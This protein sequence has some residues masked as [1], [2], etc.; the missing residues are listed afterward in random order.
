MLESEAD[1]RR[2]GITPQETALAVK[3]QPVRD[4]LRRRREATG[5]KA[6]LLARLTRLEKI[7]GLAF[8][9]SAPLRILLER[10]P[11]A[12]FDVQPE[13]LACTAR[14][15]RSI[16][17]SV[18]EQLAS[19]K[20]SYD[21]IAAEAARRRREAGHADA[22]RALSS[23]V[24]EQPGDAAVARDVA[25]S[26]LELG[27]P[28]H[29]YWLFER[30][31]ERR[32][33]E[34]QTWLALAESAA[35]LDSPLAV[36]YHEVALGAQ[37]SGRIGAMHEICQ[38]KYVRLLRR[39]AAAGT[40]SPL[41][42]YV[43]A[44]LE[45]LAGELPAADLVVVME[46]NTD[47]TDIDLHVTDP[48]GE[49]CYYKHQRTKMGGRLTDDV[50]AGFGPEMFVLPKAAPGEYL[51][52]AHYFN[53]DRSRLSMRTRVYVTIVRHWGTDRE[54]VTRKVVTLGREKDVKELAR[55][56]VR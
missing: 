3:V 44:R 16:P 34:P 48:A 25:Y 27:F 33:Y 56:H 21:A 47:E 8:E 51:V 29:A 24:E 1:Y 10:L 50:T 54:E 53:E 42:A 55:V 23:L 12:A 2:F 49:E 35:E 5:R 19:H 9:L 11:E 18:Q 32:P 30:V 4:T 39:L 52:R 14:D 17:G 36:L 45:S 6:E 37:W 26:T 46:W 7:R 41:G 28:G 20:L 15:R 40:D 38:A 31:A 43:A 13:A 22:L